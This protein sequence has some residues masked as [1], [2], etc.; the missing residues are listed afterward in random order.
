MNKPQTKLV[1]IQTRI[2]T[3]FEYYITPDQGAFSYY[4]RNNEW[5]KLCL[6]ICSG[7][8]AFFI[9][10]KKRGGTNEFHQIHT[11]VANAFI[12][13]RNIF[14]TEIHHL[15][16]DKVNNSADNLIWLTRSE[17]Q[18]IHKEGARG[19][20]TTML[21]VLNEEREFCRENGIRFSRNININQ[22]KSKI[23]QYYS[24]KSKAQS[25][26]TND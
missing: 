26:T 18:R 2:K 8:L 7:Y 20:F 24:Q 12:Q 19:E 9:G 6:C 13:K 3:R 22:L 1:R 17:H 4:P 23:N 25:L 11:E 5:K 21:K 10:S 14:C 16:M 15:D